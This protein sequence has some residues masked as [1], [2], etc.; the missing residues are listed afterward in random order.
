MN[1]WFKDKFNSIGNWKSIQTL[2]PI[3]TSERKVF[4]TN[5]LME[6]KSKRNIEFA[7][8][9]N[10]EFILSEKNHY[11]SYENQWW[12]KSKKKFKMKWM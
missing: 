2:T 3:L 9:L 8:Y 5:R 11:F 12:D 6:S 7:L 1:D 4:L 10:E